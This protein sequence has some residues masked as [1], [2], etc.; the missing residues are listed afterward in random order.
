MTKNYFFKKDRIPGCQQ[1]ED[2]NYELE[3]AKANNYKT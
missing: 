3:T 1:E 2:T